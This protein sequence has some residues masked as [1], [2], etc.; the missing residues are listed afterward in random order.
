MMDIGRPT[1]A[2]F[3]RTRLPVRYYRI[4]F[5]KAQQLPRDAD[6]RGA[7]FCSDV[8]DC[9]SMLR[10]LIEEVSPITFL[11]KTSG[12][13]TF[14]AGAEGRGEATLAYCGDDRW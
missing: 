5:A 13:G 4:N 11:S 1:T 2:N 14:G 10:V 9:G 3:D 12:T 7:S 6:P 8:S